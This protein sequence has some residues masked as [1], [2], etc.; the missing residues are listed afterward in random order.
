MGTNA[1]L[2][3]QVSATN[4][5]LPW[6][7]AGVSRRTWFRNRRREPCP[8]P[9]LPMLIV[10]WCC[11]QRGDRDAAER[12]FIRMMQTGW[13]TTA[14]RKDVDRALRAAIGLVKRRPMS[15]SL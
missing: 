15:M 1:K 12:V 8:D 4:G 10:L 2:R 5:T 13:S 7:E 9:Y 14:D 3:K 11:L 6:Q